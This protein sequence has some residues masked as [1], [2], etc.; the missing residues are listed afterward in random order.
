MCKEFSKEMKKEFEMSLLGEKSFFLGSQFTQ[1]SKGIFILLAKYIKEMLNKFEM[2]HCKHVSTPMIIGFKLSKKDES[3][4]ENQT[5]YISVNS[6]LL[7]VT[8]SMLDI[9]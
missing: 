4:E 9:M 3:K 2:K 5:L 7:Y 1:S 6:I 8:N